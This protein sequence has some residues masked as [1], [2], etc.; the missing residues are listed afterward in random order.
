MV[1]HRHA[2]IRVLYILLGK[3]QFLAFAGSSDQF[4]NVCPFEGG[5][6]AGAAT[7]TELLL[8]SSIAIK[9]GLVGRCNNREQD[10]S[11]ADK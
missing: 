9:G 11:K 4:R 2:G 8:L 3:L 7:L 10:M 5:I 1:R 6:S